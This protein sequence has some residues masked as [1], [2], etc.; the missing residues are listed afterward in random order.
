MPELKIKEFTFTGSVQFHDRLSFKFKEEV[1]EGE[2][3]A[4]AI[5]RDGVEKCVIRLEKGLLCFYNEGK[6]E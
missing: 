6:L 3:L 2:K 1:I 4:D 5:L